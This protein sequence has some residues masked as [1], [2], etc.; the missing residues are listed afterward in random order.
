MN[1]RSCFYSFWGSEAFPG[2][3]GGSLVV[4]RAAEIEL[5]QQ[6]PR[7]MP[8]IEDDDEDNNDGGVHD[9]NDDD[10]ED[11]PELSYAST[12]WEARPSYPPRQPYYGCHI[13]HI[14]N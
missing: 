3:G 9:G 5:Y 4:W 10:G 12:G 2:K 6:P 13:S 1:I 14:T 7:D 11:H 8:P